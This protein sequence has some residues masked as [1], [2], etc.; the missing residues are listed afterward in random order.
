M[1][2]RSEGLAELARARFG[3]RLAFVAAFLFSAFVNLLLLTAPLY[4]LQVYDRVL[5]S[6]SEETLIALSLLAAGL[7]VLMGLL[8]HARSRILARCGAR[9][10]AALDDRV[11]QA[12]MT[13]LSVAPADTPA[14]SAQS[15]LDALARL[16]AS[17]ALVALFDAPW[18]PVFLAAIFIFHPVLGW[19]AVAGGGALVLIAVLNQRTSSAS[20]VQANLASLEAERLARTHGAEAAVIRALGMQSAL[21]QR[22]LAVRARA[23]DHGLAAADTSGGWAVLTRTLRLFLQSAILG[24]AAWLLLRDAVSA[25]AMLAASVLMGRAL[26]PIEQAVAH[27]GT[28]IRGRQAQ[29]RLAELLSVS[30][31]PA[32]RTALPR[33]AARLEVKD[34]VVAAGGATAPVLRGVGFVLQPGQ[35]MGVIG[36]SGSGK[37]SLAQVLGGVVAPVSGQVRLGGATLDQYDPDRLGHLLGYL[38]QRSVLFPGTVAE[39]IARFD[40][41]AR[42]DQIVAAAQAAGAHDMILRLPGGYDQLLGAFGAGLSGGQAQ[43]V[44]LA[45]AL[46]GDPV[47]LIL[48][49][50]NANL[51]AEGSAALNQA[52]RSAKDRGAAVL[53][54]AHRPAAL[55]ECDLLLVLREGRVV[56]AGPREDVLRQALRNGGEISR[57]LAIGATA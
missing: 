32:V 7:F 56:A 4:M 49:E 39:N 13:R 17:P 34:L 15:D 50:P 35:A 8:D 42:A 5:V 44:A 28:V 18:T 31:P 19:V 38:P 48:D 41:M 43:R 22:L 29:V 47:L 11:H 25:G 6:R 54:M 24:V 57:A 27:W 46:Y 1:T 9:L 53:V 51:D 37:T 40:P 30:P 45:R 21:A 2:D 33:P 12:A 55:Q 16:W 3:L 20:L 10:Q 26:Q 23:L 36:P 52:V 14:L